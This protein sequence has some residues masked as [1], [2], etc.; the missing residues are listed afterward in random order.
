VTILLVLGVVLVVFGGLVL[1]LFPDRPGGKLGWQG[2][3]VSSVGA[4]LPVIVI[5]V[6]AVGFAALHGNGLDLGSGRPK[7][8]SAS[9]G[10]DAGG[11]SRCLATVFQG[12]PPGRTRP[13][14]VGAKAL[15]VLTVGQP[16]RAPVALRLTDPGGKTIGGVVFSYNEADQVFRLTR[17]VDA[18]CKPVT[19]LRDSDDPSQ[20]PHLLHQWH[21]LR[22]QLGRKFY[23]LVLGSQPPIQATFNTDG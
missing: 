7:A 11:G 10:T 12:I 3:E 21:T 18:A 9:S 23:S 16:T 4:G 13:V 1:L 17:I 20:N 2:F 5:G 14:P 15:S 6:V 8:A 22:M 19:N